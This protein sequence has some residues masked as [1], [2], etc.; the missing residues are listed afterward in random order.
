MS[1]KVPLY[2]DSSDKNRSGQ[3]LIV[4][5]LDEWAERGAAGTSPYY[6]L[7]AASHRYG[8]QK[9]SDFRIGWTGCGEGRNSW[10]LEG[11]MQM[12]FLHRSKTGIPRAMACRPVRAHQRPKALAAR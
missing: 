10:R 9:T 1:K 11:S 7:S 12:G 8:M 2:K 3:Q 4:H 5:V 6:G